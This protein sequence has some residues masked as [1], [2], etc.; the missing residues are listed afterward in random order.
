MVGPQPPEPAQLGR[1][2]LPMKQRNPMPQVHVPPH[3]SAPPHEVPQPVAQQVP[4]L[5]QTSPAA[6][7]GAHEPPQPSG[8]HDLPAHCGTQHVLVVGSHTAPVVVSQSALTV[9]VVLQPVPAVLHA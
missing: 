3:A 9:H 2:Q 4:S 7:P 6:Q 8:P 1:Q 5:L